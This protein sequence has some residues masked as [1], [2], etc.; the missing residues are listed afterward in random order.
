[1]GKRAEKFFKQRIANWNR[2]LRER[3]A[4]FKIDQSFV[5]KFPKCKYCGVSLTPYNAGL[6]HQI[7]ISRGGKDNPANLILCCQKC[8]RAKSSFSD[9]EYSAL[10]A[11][12]D[13]PPFTPEMKRRLIS[14][15]KAAWRVQ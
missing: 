11:F 15:L 12:L 4:Q 6:D 7:P 5:D 13:R 14:K 3:K 9:V 1:M 2:G 8:N 10:L